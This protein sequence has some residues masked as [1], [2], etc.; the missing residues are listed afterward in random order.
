MSLDSERSRGEFLK[1]GFGGCGRRHSAVFCVTKHAGV[2]RVAA[3]DSGIQLVRFKKEL[4]GEDSA[5]ASRLWHLETL[6]KCDYYCCQRTLN[7]MFLAI[8]RGYDSQFAVRTGIGLNGCYGIGIN[9]N[10]HAATSI[11]KLYK[12]HTTHH[13]FAWLWSPACGGSFTTLDQCCPSERSSL[14]AVGTGLA[15]SSFRSIL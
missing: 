10:R 3:L 6:L 13:I 12:L 1:I 2:Q 7:A 8:L 11:C 15:G 9:P 5:S 4:A 14:P